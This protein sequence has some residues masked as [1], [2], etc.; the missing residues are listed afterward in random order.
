LGFS[1]RSSL[2]YE[3]WL[4]KGPQGWKIKRW[5]DFPDSVVPE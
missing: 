3:G 2:N 1:N 5:H 4:V